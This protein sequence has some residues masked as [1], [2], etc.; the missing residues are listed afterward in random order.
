MGGEPESR[1]ESRIREDKGY[2]YY[3]RSNF[4]SNKYSSTT[5][6]AFTS[7]RADVTDSSVVELLAEIDKIKKLKVG[8]QE[9]KDIKSAYFGD[10][11]R[12]SESPTTIAQYS[13]DIKIEELENDYY[14]DFIRNVNQ[15]TSND[16]LKVSKKY[17]KNVKLLCHFYSLGSCAGCLVQAG[18][19]KP[20][21]APPS[22][23]KVPALRE[24]RRPSIGRWQINSEDFLAEVF[25][26]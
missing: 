6:N 10:F 20:G 14:K 23:S 12:E 19:K 13:V 17:F 7:S 8:D 18:G 15:V 22:Y 9:L 21:M 5:F 11:V 3:A 26:P 4:G 2:A 1:L 24:G 25:H 16:I